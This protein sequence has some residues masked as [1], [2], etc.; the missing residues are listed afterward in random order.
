MTTKKRIVAMLLALSVFFSTFGMIGA[1]AADVTTL[2][3]EKG[4]FTITVV[5]MEGDAD[6]QPADTEA[7]A[8]SDSD[9][10]KDPDDPGQNEGEGDQ[11]TP[12]PDRK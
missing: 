4:A 1:A 12:L 2:E 10:P 8:S 6:G 3:A 5:P 11:G 9:A 7:G